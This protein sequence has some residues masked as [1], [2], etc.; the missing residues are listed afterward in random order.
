[1]VDGAMG[2]KK[3]MS[4]GEFA[5]KLER[6]AVR[7]K[8][9]LGVPTEEYMT[10]VATQ[11]KEAIGGY[12]LGWPELAE[13][14]QADRVSKGYSADEPLLRTGALAGSIQHKAEL[15]SAGAEGLVYSDDPITAY[16][17]LGTRHIPARSFLF[18][19]LWLNTNHM[20]RIFGAF[21]V[22]ILTGD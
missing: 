1:M 8:G 19:P 11:A 9:E 14:T 13:S 20:A 22:K 2:T 10:V 7:A 18:K 15:T 16:Q 5:R 12:S 4:P 3:M 17:E 6:A 21:A